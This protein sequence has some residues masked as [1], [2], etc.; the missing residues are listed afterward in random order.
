MLV[1]KLD[2]IAEPYRLGIQT[3]SRHDTKPILKRFTYPDRLER[4]S[5]YI[6]GRQEAC[7]RLC[8]TDRSHDWHVRRT[9]GPDYRRVLLLLGKNLSRSSDTELTVGVHSRRSNS[10]SPKRNALR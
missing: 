5:S 7:E 3:S 10:Y 9:S 4:T 1:T 6:G 8:L 2:T